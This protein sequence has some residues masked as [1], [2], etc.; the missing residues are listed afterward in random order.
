[1]RPKVFV[2]EDD[3][4]LL[5]TVVHYLEEEGFQAEGFRDGSSFIR[6][7]RDDV[8]HLVLLDVMLP[9]HDGFSLA[10]YLKT[11][12]ATK[13][14]PIVFITVKG[15]EDDRL[16]GF[17]LGADDYITKPFSLR[18][19]LARIRAVLR[20]SGHLKSEG[21]YQL[22]ELQIDTQKME[23]RRGKEKIYL[24]PTEFKILECLLENYG[25]PVSREYLI[26]AV[27]KKDVYD[28]T[29]DVHVKN[30]R[31]KLGKEGQAIRTVRG[32]GYKIEL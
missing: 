27:L 17:E 30:L 8:P 31:E 14:V 2:V 16:K 24:T 15:M 4:D 18:E 6:R 12:P 25:R 26:E 1:M 10:R 32:I 21:I 3:I 11:N 7:I 19:L 20:R 5:E 9:D 28:R 13:S 29:I 22:G 23:V